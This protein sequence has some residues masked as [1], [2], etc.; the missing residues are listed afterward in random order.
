M[1][2][3]FSSDTWADFRQRY[4]N[5]YG[6][7]EKENG[8]Q[9]L[10]RVAQVNNALITFL[11]KNEITYTAKVD[12]GNSFYFIP[13]QKGLGYFGKDI[14]CSSRVPARQWKRGICIE[15]TRMRNLSQDELV[16]ITHELLENFLN[17]ELISK[18]LE[19]FKQSFTGHV[20]LNS[21]LSFT[22]NVMIYD[23]VIGKLIR[24]DRKI[25][26]KS[27]TFLQEVVDALTHNGLDIS[28]EVT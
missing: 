19:E 14:I 15:N 16:D 23:N 24:K 3:L 12:K 13:V 5:T 28:V 9:V 21:F 6:W 27:D 1:K 7:Y 17:K 8:E 10:V 2:E 22:N 26:L 4:S 18:R 11:D 20:I 25:I